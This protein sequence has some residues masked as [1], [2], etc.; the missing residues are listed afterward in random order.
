MIQL[1]YNF[2][3]YMRCLDQQKAG[4]MVKTNTSLKLFP[5][6]FAFFF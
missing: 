5:M 2:F 6:Y 1:D 3:Q 4:I